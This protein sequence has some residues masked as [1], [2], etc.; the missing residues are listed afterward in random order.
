MTDKRELIPPEGWSDFFEELSTAGHGLRARVEAEEADGSTR[1]VV[2]DTPFAGI[3]RGEEGVMIDLA[4]GLSYSAGTVQSLSTEPTAGNLGQLVAFVAADGRRTVLYLTGGA[5]LD[6]AVGDDPLTAVGGSAGA[7]GGS[8]AVPSA[9]GREDADAG[10]LV[11]FG[12]S[13]DMG[14]VAPVGGGSTGDVDL[15]GAGPYDVTNDVYD[16]PSAALVDAAGTHAGSGSETPTAGAAA[17][18]TNQD[19]GAPGQK[20]LYPDV[21]DGGSGQG[22]IDT[23]IDPIEGDKVVPGTDPDDGMVEG[24]VGPQ[25]ERDLDDLG[26]RK[27]KRREPRKAD[28]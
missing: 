3:S 4:G 26:G 10:G 9:Q 12:R 27:R 19:S 11:T 24:E 7:A 5:L 21:I 25:V 1:V 23:G 28:A 18:S 6:R 15:S 14:G 13:D 17:I 2:A 8:S 20:H 16:G 22:L